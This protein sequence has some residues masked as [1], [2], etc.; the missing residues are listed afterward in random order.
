[1][2]ISVK[3]KLQLGFGVILL[4]L[5]IVSGIGIFYLKANN[6]ILATIEQEQRTVALYNDI[7][8][9]TVRANAAIRGYMFYEKEDMKKNHYEI[10]DELHNA[11]TQLQ[12]AGERS[13]EFDAFLTQL[14][15]WETGIDQQIL[16]LLVNN[17]KE[18][19]GT[20]A[21]PILGQG[22]QNLVVFGKK[23]ANQ[24]TAEINESVVATQED[25]KRKLLQMVILIAI[26][27]ATSL[28]ISTLFGRKISKNINEM[29]IK[30]NEFA[31]GNLLVNLQ[32][33]SRDEFG[34][35]SVSF[36]EMTD[37]LRRIMK[38][39][40]DSSE[41]VAA[42]SE[43]LTASSNEVSFA[44]EVVTESIHDISNGIDDQNRL[45]N[46][47]NQLSSNVLRKMNDI[48]QNIIH[49]NEATRTTKGL[50]DRGYQSVEHVTEQMTII[51]DNTG[52][53][54][55]HVDGL[56]ANTK[57]IAQAVNVIKEIATQTNLLAINA[58][59]EAARSGEHG[60]GFAVVATEVRKLADESNVAAVEIENIVSTITRY[61]ENIIAG[62]IENDRS[63]EIGR[64]R[65]DVA[66][67]SFSHI[68]AAVIDVQRQAEAVTAAVQ[69]AYSD[70]EKLVTDIERMNDV[71][72]QSNENTQSVAASAEEQNAAMEEVAAASTYLSQMA[73]ELQETIRTF[74]Y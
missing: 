48:T 49:V 50:A 10:R 35:L 32:L 72:V 2:K 40:G 39:V 33:T 21:L 27:V 63:V 23:M 3:T 19:A 41:Q 45:A 20:V 69:H 30:M 57:T 66:S 15:E 38:K 70:I 6:E 46:E 13:T 53:L 14:D 31:D 58:S 8:F 25:G 11:I 44:T 47:V 5:L 51:S 59:I 36:N 61:T 12:D 54:T 62:I 43:Q 37:K 17:Q 24:M 64:K 18:Q 28:V 71:S 1:M 16:P 29:A 52:T 26:A 9:H 60:K 73:I 42:T 4:F 67:K 68:D 74:K 65:V 34:Q 55:A 22:S 56:D 7:A